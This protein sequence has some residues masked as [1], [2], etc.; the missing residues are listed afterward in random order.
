M[1]INSQ[2]FGTSNVVVDVIDEKITI[3]LLNENKNS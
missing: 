3:S 1:S 2:K